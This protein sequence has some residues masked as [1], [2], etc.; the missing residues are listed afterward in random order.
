M[1]SIFSSYS[2]PLAYMNTMQAQANWGVKDDKRHTNDEHFNAFTIVLEPLLKI[3]YNTNCIKNT[4][5]VE[6]VCCDVLALFSTK[7]SLT[8][9]NFNT[10]IFNLMRMK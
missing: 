7:H 10:Y 4:T 2:E 5:G 9:N 1:A 8:M 6:V 3:G